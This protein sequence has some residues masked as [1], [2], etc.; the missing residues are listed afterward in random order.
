MVGGNSPGY[1]NVNIGFEVYEGNLE[2]LPPGYQEVTF[3]IIFDVNT[4]ENFRRK[5]QMVT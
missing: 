3:H 2:E 4:G 5:T 1:E